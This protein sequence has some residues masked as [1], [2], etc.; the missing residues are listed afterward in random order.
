[1]NSR[2]FL[3]QHLTPGT[4]VHTQLDTVA[5]SGM[6]RTLKVHAVINGEIENITRDVAEVL[7]CKMNTRGSF[8]VQGAGM[9]MGFHTVYSLAR[10]LHG[11]GYALKHRWL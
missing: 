5:K 8:R 4:T 7:G 10:E 3:K 9:D 2:E 11:D 1:M 6:S